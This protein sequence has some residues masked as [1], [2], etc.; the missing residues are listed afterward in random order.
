MEILKSITTIILTPLIA[1]LGFIGYDL[2]KEN[3]IP[4]QIEQ[5]VEEQVEQNFGAFSPT[6]G[7]TYRLQSSIN[8]SATTIKLSS[9]KEP[10]SLLPYTM[11]YLN[12]AIAYGTIN[13][14]ISN[15]SEFVS[16]TGITQNSDGTATLTGVSRGLSR[17][18]PYTA[19]TTLQLVHPGQSI[20]ILS[21]SPQLFNE[22]AV[23]RN[24]ETISGSW[25][26]P[27]PTAAGNPT[28]K[29][30]V[31]A[32]VNGGT[33]STDSIA[34][35]AI[36]GETVSSGEILYFNQ[37]EGEWRKADAD[38]ASTT[39]GVI[40]G[41]AQGSGTDGV[42]ISG[43]VILR[44]VDSKNPGGI[45]G[46]FV[47]LSNTAGATSTSAGT[48]DRTI[49]IMKSTSQFYFDPNFYVPS[50]MTGGRASSTQVNL[51]GYNQQASTTQ[52]SVSS[53]AYFTGT[54]T[55]ATTTIKTSA[56]QDYDGLSPL[57]V[58]LA[59]STVSTNQSTTTVSFPARTIVRIFIDGKINQNP[60]AKLF[61]NGD[62][63]INYSW[64][65]AT[66]TP[67]EDPDG[68]GQRY[69]PIGRYGGNF[70]LDLEFV[71][72]VSTTHPV[73]LRGIN[74]NSTVP[75]AFAS[76]SKP[77]PF[78]IAGVWATS[79]AQ[80]ITSVSIA[81]DTANN[82]FAGTKIYVYGSSF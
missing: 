25:T 68:V 21:D 30:Y 60:K 69:I 7:A 31:D 49:G 65:H 58:Q 11:T 16:F 22:Y 18:Y 17:S 40:L 24:D 8:S 75:G 4:A 61:F 3:E 77:T 32:L 46:R 56:V 73:F 13:P 50:L 47:Y 28:P 42:G 12:T 27:T 26:V 34:V 74:E 53:N 6:G 15:R 36:A 54:T 51:V 23:K 59:S 66:S 29:S 37:Y 9:F 57:W 82:V 39:L 38:L 19:S 33:V 5:K 44:G 35:A 81:G 67:S 76:T 63:G 52:L 10:V 55:L 1:G 78:S 2:P 79:T 71:N 43:G 70:S 62:D 64:V 14:G 48:V 72:K 45:A 80:Q 41:V 20:F